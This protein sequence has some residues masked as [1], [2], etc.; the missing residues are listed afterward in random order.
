MAKVRPNR[1]QE[2]KQWPT[3]YRRSSA[4]LL[5]LLTGCAAGPNFE[6]PAAP[7]VTGYIHERIPAA[8]VAA[9][10]ERQTFHAGGTIAAD[11]WLLFH[12]T[13]LDAVVKQAIANNATLQSAQASLRQS[14]ENLKAGYGVFYPSLDAGF[15]A[16]RQRTSPLRLGINTAGG[17]FNLFTL[18]T[19]ISYALDVFG[20]ERRT[21]EAL[22]AQ[23]DYQNYAMLATYLTLTG[24]VVNTVIARAAYQAQIRAIEELIARQKEQLDIAETQAS[25]G[26]AAYSSVLSINS[27]LA[28]SEATVPVL[29]Q[30]SDQAEHLLASLT[31]SMPVNWQAPTLDLSAL[32][33]PQEL[34]LSLPSD[35][36]RQRPDILEAESLLHQASA[37]IGIATAALFPSFNLSGAYGWN[38]RTIGSLT[39]SDAKFWDIGPS[40]NIP[41]FH[42]GSL[43]HRRQASIE[44]YRKSLADYRQA[45][46]NAFSQVADVLTALE[47][48][49][50]F[51]QAQTQALN[52]ARQALALVQANYRAGLVSYL[53]VLTADTQFYQA[54]I[55]HVQAVAQRYQDTTALFLALGGGWWENPPYAGGESGKKETRR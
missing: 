48:D 26:T 44:A 8:T 6:R 21:V 46:L 17:L 19:T 22:A 47:H 18:S 9:E 13:E 43:L 24:N 49:A 33:L 16:M 15:S 55:N 4:I 28:S 37:G 1:P 39:A 50:Q 3:V 52:S 42:G 30:K 14:Q 35:L 2:I 41:L 31:G 51:L 12:S 32:V 5:L 29:R 20:G 54:Q 45:V 27:Q 10:T 34:P 11:W 53:D 36:V 25:A 38:N 7:E 23:A 40:V